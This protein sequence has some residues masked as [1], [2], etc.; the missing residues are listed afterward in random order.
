MKDRVYGWVVALGTFALR[1]MDVRRTV[2]GAEHLPAEGGVVLAVSHFSYVDFVLSEWAIWRTTRRHTR[3]LATRAAFDNRFSGPLMSAMGHIPVDQAAG[4]SAYRIAVRALRRGEIVGVFPETRVSGSFTLL[5]FKNG[6]ARMA[7]Q[8]GC[9]IVPC[10]IWGS[11]RIKTRTHKTAL[12]QARHIPVQIVFGEPIH[13]RPD[14]DPSVVTETLHRVMTGM[15]EQA[16]DADE[17]TPG[18][19]WVPAHRGGGA[20]AADLDPEALDQRKAS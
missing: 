18:G 14:D 2:W 7:A 12:R 19:W 6:A 16:M 10:V 11:H 8:S 13:V 20:P 9:P 17:L 15:L 1:L 5:P 3:F 4:A